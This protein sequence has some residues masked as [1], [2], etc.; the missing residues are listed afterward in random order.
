MKPF[1][2]VINQPLGIL[3][4]R[5]KKMD[6]SRSFEAADQ[7][8]KLSFIRKTEIPGLIVGDWSKRPFIYD[9]GLCN[10]KVTGGLSHEITNEKVGFSHVLRIIHLLRF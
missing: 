6:H 10:L 8:F 9:N 1:E 5:I 7:G 3:L 4:C 2:K